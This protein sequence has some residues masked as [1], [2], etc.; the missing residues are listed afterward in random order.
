MLFCRGVQRQT[1]RIDDDQK[2]DEEDG[3]IQCA[4]EVDNYLMH[5]FNDMRDDF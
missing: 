3:T 2:Y 4:I 5:I 1:R